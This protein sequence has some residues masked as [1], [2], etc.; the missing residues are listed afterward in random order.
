MQS[1]Y[2]HKVNHFICSSNVFSSDAG[3]KCGANRWGGILED[4]ST[5]GK[6]LDPREIE[7]KLHFIFI[8]K[9]YY[10]FRVMDGRMCTV[11]VFVM[12]YARMPR[13]DASI[14]HISFTCLVFVNCT[15][16]VVLN[17]QIDPPWIKMHP[18]FLSA[19]MMDYRCC[20]CAVCFG[21]AQTA[22]KYGVHNRQSN[23]SDQ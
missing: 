9:P 16:A 10:F 3:R 11:K 20:C 12:L 4:E 21:T 6:Y 2:R 7:R 14:I 1:V 5:T 15:S 13:D 17:C 22:C 19:V 8:E 23:N 18:C